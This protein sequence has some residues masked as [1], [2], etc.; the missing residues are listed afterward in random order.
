VSSRGVPIL[1]ALDNTPADGQAEG[2]TFPKHTTKQLKTSQ[3]LLN[4]PAIQWA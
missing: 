4:C 2:F 3:F 1:L